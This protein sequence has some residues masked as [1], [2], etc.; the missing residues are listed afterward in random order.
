MKNELAARGGCVDALLKRPEPDTPSIKLGDHVD[1]VAERPTKS[2]E[3]PNDQAV[4]GA[5]KR[6]RLGETRSVGFGPRSVVG[7][8]ALATCLSES[9]RLQVDRL[10]YLSIPAY[11]QCSWVLPVSIRNLK[12]E[13]E[14]KISRRWIEM[15]GH[16]Q[17]RG[18]VSQPRGVL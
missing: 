16:P 12:Q 4:S 14:A 17:F 8:D 10:V 13:R 18:R 15:K 1:E 6:K 5:S 2:V 7:E 9:I 3:A 11:I